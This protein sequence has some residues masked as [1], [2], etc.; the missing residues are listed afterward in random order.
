M[1]TV[2]SAD[3]D[4]Q[5]SPRLSSFRNGQ[6][7]QPSNAR[8]VKDFEGIVLQQALL[9]VLREKLVFGVLAG[10]AECCLREVIR[11]KR[12][13]VGCFGKLV[14]RQT[15]PDDFDHGTEAERS[16]EHTSEL[17]SRENLVC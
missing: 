12:E 5:V 4:L 3:A 8:F 14:G 10:E 1:A 9:Y 16:E 13:E 2:L 7:H 17:Q 15:R 6:S 11:S